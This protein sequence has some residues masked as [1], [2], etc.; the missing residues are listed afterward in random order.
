MKE[1]QI[2]LPGPDHPI[3]IQRNPARVVVSVAGRV[4]ADTRNAL[5]LR[6]VRIRRFNTFQVRT[7]IFPSW[8]GRI[9]LPTALTKAIA[10]I[11]AFPLE[12]RSPS[13]RCGRMRIRSLVLRR[14]KGM[15]RSIPIG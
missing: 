6:E 2:T 4:V 8:N 15:L 10:L 7:L 14:S 11:T 3:S 1:K 5:T 13:T 9:T 12:E